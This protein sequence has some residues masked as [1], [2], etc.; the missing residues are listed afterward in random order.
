MGFCE[1]D[2]DGCSTT[3]Y[4]KWTAVAV[5]TYTVSFDSNGGT[6]ISA[7]SDV[8]QGSMIAEPAEPT[9][10]GYT[11]AG[12]YE[13]NTIFSIPWIFDS[14]TV[15]L[16]LTLYAKWVEGY[17]VNFT[18]IGGATNGYAQDGDHG[19][20]G[21]PLSIYFIGTTSGGTGY[22]QVYDV[23]GLSDPGRFRQRP[24]YTSLFQGLCF[25]GY[26]FYE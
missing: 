8:I 12:W 1:R 25:F 6:G 10:T 11:F 13:D 18:T 7:I 24:V 22:F 5:A 21:M 26:L 3:L 17:N 19:S 4:A 15:V 2:C 23:N 14:S 16:D 20:T 9:L